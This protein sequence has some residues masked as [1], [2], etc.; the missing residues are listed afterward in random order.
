[1]AAEMAGE[2]LF[3]MWWLKD[4]GGNLCRVIFDVLVEG[5]RRESLVSCC[6]GCAG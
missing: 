1:M 5:W 4:G 3:L 6:S 2:L